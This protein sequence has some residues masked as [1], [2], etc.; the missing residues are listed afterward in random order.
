MFSFSSIIK[1]I[2]DKCLL[3]KLL[4]FLSCGHRSSGEISTL[5][6]DH[7]H[8]S[9]EPKW[10]WLRLLNAQNVLEW[11]RDL[12]TEAK[13]KRRASLLWTWPWHCYRALSG[14]E[15]ICLSG[16]FFLLLIYTVVLR[17]AT[18]PDPD[19]TNGAGS[20]RSQGWTLGTES[21]ASLLPIAN[22]SQIP[23]TKDTLGKPQ[24]PHDSII[25]YASS[26]KVCSK[27]DQPKNF[28][29]QLTSNAYFRALPGTSLGC[30]SLHFK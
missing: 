14:P 12:E 13:G 1:P 28:L 24:N 29:L 16:L 20:L 8:F 11:K 9:S 22:H 26:L 27:V 19:H 4:V 25:Q 3:L 7:L 15:S 17:G 30:E 10:N 6:I 23:V 5:C 2:L 18:H 21:P